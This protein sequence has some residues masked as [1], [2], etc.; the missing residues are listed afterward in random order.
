AGSVCVSYGVLRFSR[1]VGGLDSRRLTV[2][3]N[4]I[5]PGPFDRAS[6]VPRGDLGIPEQAHLA[7]AVGRLDVQK[8]LADLLAAAERVI[9]Q[10]PAWHLA[11]AAPGCWSRSTHNPCLTA[12]FTG[13][14]HAMTFR[15]S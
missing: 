10:C 12:G 11:L 14:G 13:W 2:I 3:P 6:A 4:G 15:V 1:G 5:D 8:G 9:A 7:L